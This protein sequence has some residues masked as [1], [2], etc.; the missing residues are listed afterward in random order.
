MREKLILFGFSFLVIGLVQ[1][2]ATKGA[3]L[4][5]LG[6]WKLDD[7]EGTIVLD[8]SGKE[9]HGTIN[10]PNGG[11]G[12]DGSVWDI[13]PD[14]NVVLSFNGDYSNGAYVSA[15]TIPAMTLENS[16]TWAFWA[17]QDAAQG[18]N[19]DIIL[20]N[21]W[22]GSTWIK[23]TPSLFEFG[24][25]SPETSINYENIPADTW[26]HHAVVKEGTHY[27][28]Y[29]DGV[30]SLEKNISNTSDALP[31]LMGGD[32][33]GERWRGRL[34]HVRI[35][36]RA[37]SDVEIHVVMRGEPGLSSAPDP[38]NEATD[39]PRDNVVLSWTAG[40]FADKHDVYMGTDFD[41]VKNAE[42]E[43]PSGVLKIRDLDTE[44]YRLGRLEFGRK[45]YWRVDEVNAPPDLTIYKG[46]IW[47]FTTELLSYPIPGENITATTSGFTEGQGP[48]NTI[49]N[50]RMDINNL[51]SNT[52]AAMWLSDS[53][54]SG[55]AWVQ[56]DFDRIYK[57]HE[58]LVWNY[59]GALFLPGYGFKDVKVE[60]S[61]NGTDWAQ[62]DDVPEFARATG[63]SGYSANTSV[64]FS[65]IIIKSIRITAL[66]NWGGGSYKKYGL[67]EV[68]FIKIPLRAR[69][70]SPYDGASNIPIDVTLGWRSGREAAEHNVYFSTDYQ[71]AEN[72]T[73]PFVTANKAGFKP[74]MSLDLGNTYYWRVDEV[75]NTEIPPVWQGDIWSFTTSEYLVVEDF[76]SY[77]DIEAGKE[78]SNLVY[79][80]WIDGYD[81]PS[82]NGS[83]MGYSTGASMEKGTVHG[84]R[85]SAPLMY[86][87]T[88]ASLS[89]VTV[90]LSDMPIGG[91]WTIGSPEALVLWFYGDPNNAAEQMYV[92]INN[93]KVVY[94]T[95]LT[96]SEWRE[97]YVDL[98]SLSIDLS[99]ITTLTI[100]FE[101]TSDTGGSGMIII[102]DVLLYRSK[103]INN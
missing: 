77:N 58:M 81:N 49:N 15:G 50:S 57:L 89:E 70:P 100:G 43:N 42:R 22:N 76:E 84:G 62:L 39:V 16:F 34:S 60:F 80:T 98:S 45:Y 48:E 91:D 14:R 40:R 72:G 21:R 67:S 19:D 85:Q 68:R 6:W 83:T 92:K 96:Q 13:D 52:T 103:N 9:N 79:A 95:D 38:E 18:V 24:S 61:D 94:N 51:H 27:I 1:T 4:S 63:K 46:D 78:G 99:N 10:N 88:S 97:L 26:I 17:R 56:Y 2:N 65:N 35:Y 59:N 5:L 31:F 37:L 54:D 69:K 73:T 11:L 53:G 102:D 71:G 41:E 30:N 66:S 64:G 8:S 86:D 90:S 25:S 74:I 23:F 75:N 87:N 20:G 55:S 93:T 32:T 36:S 44:T 12:A 47:N 3:D 33:D 28:Y 101:S 7:G 82:V 29:R